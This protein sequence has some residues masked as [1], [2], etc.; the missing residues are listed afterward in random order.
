[1]RFKLILEVNKQA[2]GNKLPINYQYEQSAVIYKILSYGDKEYASWLHGNGFKLE[3][4]KSFKLFTFSR[5]K[6]EKRNILKREERIEILSDLV[7]WQISF[8]PEKSTQ[9]FITGLFSNQIFEIGD[10]KSA[11]QFVVKSI[12]T[13]PSLNYTSEMIFKTMSP[14][15]I[16]FKREDGKTDYLSPKDVRS[17][18]LLILGLLDRYRSYYGTSLDCT[19]E[20]CHFEVMDE[21]KSVLVAIKAGTKEQTYVRGYMCTFKIR[22]PKELLELMYESGMGNLC[23]QGFGGLKSID[24]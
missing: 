16:K 6:I 12:E 9:Q 2:F 8:L 13:M 23:A 10:K 20:E 3:N 4:G 11:V 24:K 1:M 5:F 18:K 7:E 17:K 14:I 15:C 19:W 21:P 22:A